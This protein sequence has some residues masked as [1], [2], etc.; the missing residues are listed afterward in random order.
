M[1][2]SESAGLLARRII[3]KWKQVLSDRISFAALTDYRSILPFGLLGFAS[4][5]LSFFG[6]SA[7]EALRY[8]RENVL[9]GEWW[10]L[11][12]GHLVHGTS[13]HLWLNVL[14]LVLCAALFARDYS[15]RAWALVLL[16]SA[17][18]IDVAFVFYEPQLPWYVGLSGVLH[19]VLAAGAVAWWRTEPKLLAAGLTVFVVGKLVWEQR[20]GALPLSGDFPVVVDAHLY[21][22]LGGA[23]AASILW[24]ARQPWFSRHRPL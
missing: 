16:A 9:Q 21:G 2:A 12:S 14:G 8:E 19:G 10:R 11:F 17:A 20:V 3:T 6:D 18:V 5:S 22:A 13:Q 1:L 15:A 23:L 24:A 4:I 7:R